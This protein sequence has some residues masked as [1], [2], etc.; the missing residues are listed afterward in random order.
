MARREWGERGDYR[1]AFRLTGG[2]M[3]YLVLRNRESHHNTGKWS[4]YA[5]KRVE[6]E[7]VGIGNG[8]M[9]YV[10]QTILN[11]LF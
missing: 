9:Y 2:I 5:M 8:I 6:G 7:K 3:D 4:P 11:E 1:A 10:Y